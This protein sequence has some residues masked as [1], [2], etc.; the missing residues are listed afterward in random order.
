MTNHVRLIPLNSDRF[1]G[2]KKVSLQSWQRDFYCWW[3]KQH[4]VMCLPRT[5]RSLPLSF[6]MIVS[7]IGFPR[8]IYFSIFNHFL[9]AFFLSQ[10]PERESFSSHLLSAPPVS[11]PRIFPFFK[12]LCSS[13]FSLVASQ[14]LVQIYK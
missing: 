9:F 13:C 12:T 5:I 7:V 11:T 10:R 1:S 6:L 14:S 2:E 4:D 8:S 3:R